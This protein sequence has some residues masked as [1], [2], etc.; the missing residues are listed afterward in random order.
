MSG[1]GRISFSRILELQC[2]YAEAI[3]QLNNYLAIKPSANDA[4]EV[5]EHLVMLE[6][7]RDAH[8]QK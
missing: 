2:R 3:Q 4:G 8:E 1:S 6:A 5:R 7:E